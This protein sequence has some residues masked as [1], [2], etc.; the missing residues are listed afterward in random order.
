MSYY[1]VE[2]II[3]FLK[4]NH[5][6]KLVLSSGT[7]NIPFVSLVEN[8]PWFECYSVVDERNAAFF[9]M[10]LS[11]QSSEPVGI[12]CTSGTAVSNYV[13]GITEAYYSNVQLIAITFDRSPYVLNQLETQKID[14]MS[15]FDSIV[16]KNIELP[17]IN[18]EEDIWFS[19]RIL[20]EAFIALKSHGGGPI[21]IN[22]P[23]VGS[24]NQLWEKQNGQERK[25]KYIDYY[26]YES[27]KWDLLSKEMSNKKIL[28]VLGQDISLDDS[29]K[30]MLKKFLTKTNAVLLNDNLSNFH[31]D[32]S[33]VHSERLIK[34]FNSSTIK[35]FL[36]DIVISYGLNFQERT[37]DLF[38]ANSEYLSHWLITED[39]AVKDCFKCQTKLFDCS[40]KHF[41]KSLLKM[42]LVCDKNFLNTWKKIDSSISMPAL[43]YSYFSVIRDFSLAIPKHSILHLSILNATRLM[44]FFDLDPSIKVYSNANSFGIDGCLPTFLGQAYAC[45]NTSFLVIGDLSFFYA[46]N[47]LGIRHIKNNVKVLLI[48]NG[49]GAEFHIVPSHN[50]LKTIDLHIGAAHNQTAK[51]WCESLGFSYVSA[52]SGEEFILHLK[53]F[54]KKQEKP[55]VFEVFTNMEHDGKTILEVYRDLEKQLKDVL[56][57]MEEQ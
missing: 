34:A 26:S 29:D 57:S 51:G 13:S 44:Q 16:K 39:G 18:S 37:K 42:D 32:C 8:D 4:E 38:K 40:I 21:H 35:K 55:V 48:N 33:S 52:H 49:G 24:T 46:M 11:Q 50:E 12:A 23:L 30:K 47:A 41:L 1:C 31:C 17:I 9:G 28:F 6:H 45:D 10:G 36:P 7:R 5:V 56:S 20:N 15:L 3:A 27:G 54:T 43:P 14:Q 2:I 22:I 19:E 53:Q 25:V